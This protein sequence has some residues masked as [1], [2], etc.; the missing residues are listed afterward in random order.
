M[1]RFLVAFIIPLL[2]GVAARTLLDNSHSLLSSFRQLTLLNLTDCD[3]SHVQFPLDQTTPELSPPGEGL[4]LKIAVIGR[5]TQ[6]YTCQDD[7]TG[8]PAAA[9]AVATL[10]DASCVTAKSLRLL[11][12]VPDVAVTVPHDALVTLSL[13]LST[14]VG[15]GGGETLLIGEHCF[16]RDSTPFFDFRFSGRSEWIAAVK[17]ESVPAPSS[18]IPGSVPWLKLGFQDG[19][20]V[21]VC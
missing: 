1:I 11:S 14:R 8:Q 21:K 9:G 2:S 19:E 12:G 15:N 4:T 7:P 13:D 6:N 20:G 3:V 16:T 5:G 18:A 10:F 17:D